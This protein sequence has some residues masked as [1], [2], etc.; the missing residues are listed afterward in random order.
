MRN[1][2]VRRAYTISTAAVGALVQIERLSLVPCD[3]RDWGRDGEE[4]DM[5]RLSRLLGVGFRKAPICEKRGDVEVGGRLPAVRFPKRMYCRKCRRM[6]YEPDMQAGDDLICPEPEC[7]KQPS[8]LVSMPWVVICANGHMDDVPWFSLVHQDA[9]DPGKTCKAYDALYFM[10]AKGKEAPLR[11]ECRS[12]KASLPLT[13]LRAPDLLCKHKCEGRQPWLYAGEKSCDK[14]LQVASL[15]DH[16][17][18]YP[19]VVS[20]LD[21]PPESRKDSRDNLGKR[22]RDHRDWRHL[23]EL[24]E[25]HGRE[26]HVVQQKATAIANDLKVQHTMILDLLSPSEIRIEHMPSGAPIPESHLLRQEEYQALLDRITDFR[27]YEQFITISRTAEWRSWLEHADNKKSAVIGKLVTELVGVTR[28]REVRAMKGFTRVHLPESGDARIVPPDLEGKSP[29]LPVAELYGEGIFFTLD[30][31]KLTEWSRKQSV[32]ARSHIAQQGFEASL[33]TKKVGIGPA[34]LPGFI[35]LHTL[36][37]LLIREMAFDCGYPAASLRERLYFSDGESAMT[38]VLV[39]LSAGEPGGSLGG[40]SRL[41]DPERFAAIL[42]RCVETASWCALD[43]VCAEHEGRGEAQ[44]NRAACH[45]CCLLA[46]TSCECR[47]LMLDR[48]LVVSPPDGEKTGLFDL[49]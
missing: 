4:V 38:G 13:R 7:R 48:R 25:K 5:P 15:G 19:V 18:H 17:V 16:F 3:I 27:E 33:W 36:A 35:A 49:N 45:A 47:N 29:W 8:S 46:E 22:I 39:H 34:S 40:I 2:K 9:K 41:A 28:T 32:Q 1:P 26:N 30:R 12:C 6:F 42:I 21:I 20:A 11:V 23:L 43:P 24:H 37:H 14:Q 44:L 10:P 31:H